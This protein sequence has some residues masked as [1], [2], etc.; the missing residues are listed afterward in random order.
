MRPLEIIPGKHP[1]WQLRFERDPTPIGQFETLDEAET[2]ARSF[3]REYGIDVIHVHERDGE[4]RTIH[5][6][7]EHPAPTVRDVKGPA[8]S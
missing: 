6:E 8:V 5:V 4:M 3:A 1:R 7:P 2:Q